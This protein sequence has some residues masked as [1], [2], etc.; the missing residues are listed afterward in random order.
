[1]RR[2]YERGTRGVELPYLLSVVLH[3]MDRRYWILGIRYPVAGTRFDVVA[4]HRG[5]A[6]SLVLVEAKYR[7]QGRLVRPYEV[8]RF[9]ASVRE[10]GQ[11][12]CHDAVEA[13]V[14]TNTGFS[15]QALE[16]VRE[17]GVRPV[18]HVPLLFRREE[19]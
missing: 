2:V 4:K 9:A 6:K 16:A 12:L 17:H 13:W 8:K 5:E 1:M 3:L 19:G 10:T 14:V 11:A 18:D 15:E 7:R